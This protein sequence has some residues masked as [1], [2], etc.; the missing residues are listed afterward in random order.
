MVRM[1]PLAPV[2]D[3]LKCRF[4]WSDSSDINV[5]STMFFHYSGGPPSESDA[6]TLAA[7]AYTAM[8]AP[9]TLWHTDTQLTGVEITDLSEE[10]G[11]QATHNGV[12]PGV[13]TGAPLAGGTCVVVGYSIARRYRGGKPRNY[14]PWASASDLTTRQQWSSTYVTLAATNLA[15]VIATII[16]SSGGSTT[17]T[18]HA[19]VSYYKGNDASINPRTGRAQNFPVP[20]TTPVVDTITSLTVRPAPG[21]QRR[22]NR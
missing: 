10:S 4:L 16:G 2:A 6:A 20:R 18:N 1:P 8:A 17:I 13:E 11:A 9:T 19:N 7:S 5:S 3:V 12:T 22:R 15:S 14:F 21:S